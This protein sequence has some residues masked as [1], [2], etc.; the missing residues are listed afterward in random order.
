MFELWSGRWIPK[1]QEAKT[2][3]LTLQYPFQALPNQ[4]Q[5][6]KSWVCTNFRACYH[7]KNSL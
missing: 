4:T 5:E 7:G 3:G 6:A 2:G 1:A